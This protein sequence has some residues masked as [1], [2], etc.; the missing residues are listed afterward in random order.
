M[1]KSGSTTQESVVT[2]EGT[3]FGKQRKRPLGRETISEVVRKARSLPPYD[4]RVVME[5]EHLDR[6]SKS[7]LSSLLFMAEHRSS[8]FTP[9]EK[10]E[11][12]RGIVEV[13]LEYW[14]VSVEEGEVYVSFDIKCDPETLAIR[15][16]C[17]H[18]TYTAETKR[19]LIKE[20]R[21]DW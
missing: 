14:S 18:T 11:F 19:R 12:E 8:S 5:V 1:N 2:D 21:I 16:M 4:H 7:E 20:D 17:V 15:R 9:A 3:D 13:Y 6:L 10:R